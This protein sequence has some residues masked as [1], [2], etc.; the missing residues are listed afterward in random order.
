MRWKICHLADSWVNTA[1]LKF[2]IKRKRVYRKAIPVSHWGL[3]ILSP[4]F[5]NQIRTDSNWKVMSGLVC[6]P[7]HEWKV[8]EGLE[9]R[10]CTNVVDKGNKNELIPTWP[11]SRQHC[12][13]DLRGDNNCI[14]SNLWS[15]YSI[16]LQS[17]ES[18]AVRYCAERAEGNSRP[19]CAT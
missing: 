10:N 1:E 13:Y 2:N 16:I 19:V 8:Q 7:W 17:V 3:S 14:C 11:I 18:C 9:V 5:F 12:D 4:I 15:G 6:F